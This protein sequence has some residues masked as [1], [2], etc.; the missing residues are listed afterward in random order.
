MILQFIEIYVNIEPKKTPDMCESCGPPNSSATARVDPSVLVLP[1]PH[2][3]HA[4]DRSPVVGVGTPSGCLAQGAGELW[5]M[6]GAKEMV[7]V[8]E[9]L[10][11]C[12]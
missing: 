2:G 5:G 7:V 4:C 10:G 11:R 3:R 12:F 8:S 1:R 6:V 9:S